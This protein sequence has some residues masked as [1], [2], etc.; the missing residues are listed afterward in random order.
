MAFCADCG[1]ACDEVAERRAALF[2]ETAQERLE[3]WTLG[4][5]WA[6]HPKRIGN[7]PALARLWI[8]DPLASRSGLPD[9]A[10]TLNPAGLVGMVHELSVPTLVEAYRHGLFT[11]THYGPLKWLSLDER[12]VLFF[13]RLH[14]GRTVRRLM[15]QERH[16]IT[17]D[18]DF[19][20]VIKACAGRRP[21]KWHVTWITPRIMRAYADM[22]DAGHVHSFEVWNQTGDLVGG[23]YGVAIGGAFY[24]E[25]Q[26]SRTPHASKFGFHMLNWHLAKWGFVLNDNK[27]T[28]PTAMQMGFC[29][30]PRPDFLAH[31]ATATRQPGKNGRWQVETDLKTVADWQPG[32]A[33]PRGAKLSAA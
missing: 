25:S 28:T 2:R 6:L 7:L 33:T 13:D 10:R 14:I 16:K 23:G 27:W 15:R 22:Y 19:E 31:L 21:G 8:T 26:F 20:A 30:I 32:S 9:S 12:C 11:F 17:F 1:P 3:R 24:I 18:R 4:T 29:M 5:A